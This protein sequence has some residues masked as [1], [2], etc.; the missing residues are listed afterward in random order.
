MIVY[1]FKLN[2]FVC[3]SGAPHMARCTAPVRGHRTASAAADCPACGGRYGRFGGYSSYRSYSPPSPS[4]SAPWSSGGSRSSG[5][6]PSSSARPRW[7]RAGSSVAYTPAEVRALTPI[8]ES[9]EKRAPL[10]DLRDVFLCHAWDGTCTIC[11]NHAASRSGSARRTLLS[12]RRC[13]AKSIGDWRGRE[14][15]SC[16]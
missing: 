8:R 12:A 1:R 11:S 9:V 6:G 13:S 5:G 3:R 10:P 15:G 7:S 2:R 14:L 4:Y 16:W